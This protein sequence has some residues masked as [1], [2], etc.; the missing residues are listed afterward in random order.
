MHPG[1]KD[2]FPQAAAPLLKRAL[3]MGRRRQELP[4]PDLDRGD[5]KAAGSGAGAARGRGSRPATWCACAAAARLHFISFYYGTG[6]RL[7][8]RHTFFVDG[9]D[10]RCRQNEA[11]DAQCNCSAGLRTAIISCCE[12]GPTA[13]AT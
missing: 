1:C 11:H 9:S 8:S 4:A 5:E 12:G 3:M 10:R 7:F 2:R 13:H 6:R